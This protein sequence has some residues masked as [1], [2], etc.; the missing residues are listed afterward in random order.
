MIIICFKKTKNVSFNCVTSYVNYCKSIY[1]SEIDTLVVDVQ[2]FIAVNS[3][4]NLAVFSLK[5]VFML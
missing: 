3:L 1:S 4:P 5:N 2:T